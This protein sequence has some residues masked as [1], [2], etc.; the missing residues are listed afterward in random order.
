[1]VSTPFR[2]WLWGSNHGHHY[3]VQRQSPLD[4]LMIG[5]KVTK[6]LVSIVLVELE[7]EESRKN[8][9]NAQRWKQKNK[10]ELLSFEYK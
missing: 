10:Q 5:N 7:I 3:Q 2:L 4:Q 1:V 9:L 6:L 8:K